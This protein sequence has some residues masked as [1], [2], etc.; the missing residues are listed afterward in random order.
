MTKILLLGASGMLGSA[1]ANELSRSTFEYFLSSRNDHFF[2]DAETDALEALLSKFSLGAEDYVINCIG[3]VKSRISNHSPE[4]VGRAI[5]VNSLFPRLLEDL[6]SKLGFR[7]IMPATDCVFSGRDGGYMENDPHDAHDIYGKTKSLGESLAPNTMHLR[8]SLIGPELGKSSLLFEWVRRQSQG[9]EIT[10]FTNHLWNGIPSF[11]FAEIALGVIRG[12]NFRCGVQHLVPSGTFSKH[13]L[14]QQLLGH[15]GRN[16]VILQSISTETPVD[17][18]LGTLDPGF[19]GLLFKGAGYADI[20]SI[21]ESVR[22][23]FQ[24]FGKS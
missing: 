2:F 4:S 8:S 14:I 7:V 21:S 19:N 16:D 24:S 22:S 20:P 3:I 17:R 23:M 18:T 13:D 12:N 10:G 5:K 11:L 6:A 15:L 9:A 1:I